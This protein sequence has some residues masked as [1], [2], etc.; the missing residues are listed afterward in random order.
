MHYYERLTSDETLK[1]KHAKRQTLTYCGVGAHHQKGVAEKAIKDL[2]DIA[3]TMLLHAQRPWPTAINQNLWSY[4]LNMAEDMYNNLPLSKQHIT[5][6]ELFSMAAVHPAT[7]HF[8]HLRC[9]VYILNN[10][11]QA[12]QELGKWE[13]RARVAI[14]LGNSPSHA[15]SVALVL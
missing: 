2:Q 13:D 1:A 12:G 4:A 6:M 9:D 5:P 15:R 8:H 3:R 11:M 10:K 7:K 14:Y